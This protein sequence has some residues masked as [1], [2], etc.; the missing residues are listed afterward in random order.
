MKDRIDS[1][2]TDCG[3]NSSVKNVLIKGLQAIGI[4]AAI[5]AATAVATEAGLVAGLTAG[6]GI[7]I[8]GEATAKATK[9]GEEAA[10]TYAISQA[11]TEEEAQSY[12]DLVMSMVEWGVIGLSAVGVY[13]GVKGKAPA[14]RNTF[15]KAKISELFELSRAKKAVVGENIEVGSVSESF[16]TKAAGRRKEI[17]TSLF[18]RKG[19]NPSKRPTWRQS[20]IDIAMSYKKNGH[21]VETQKCFKDGKPCKSGTKD[22]I[23]V[24]TLVDGKLDV[25]SKNYNLTTNVSSLINDI[26]D[27]AI[28]N[29]KHLP[30]GVKQLYK[31]DTRGQICTPEIER[32]IRSR[33]IKKCGTI[34][35]PKDID[36]I[37]E[38]S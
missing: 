1:F 14:L 17:K 6:A 24:D 27:Q 10:V 4:G 22:S 8:A 12:A 32:S 13:K 21:V 11:D 7:F 2:A 19:E 31:I 37:R 20:E 18:L 28:K 5:G 25:E 29:N 33:I 15:S 23:R 30:S 3:W 26:A 36:F 34:I 38:L 9:F 16:T 35:S